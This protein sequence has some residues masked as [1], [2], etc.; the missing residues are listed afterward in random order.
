M[1]AERE[2]ARQGLTWPFETSKPTSSVISFPR[3]HLLSLPKQSPTW[4]PNIEIYEPI[5]ATLAQ[6]ATLTKL[7][8]IVRCTES[9]QNP[10]IRW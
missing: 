1:E 7:K 10:S 5:G 8:F 3:P 6:T 4:E 9:H 2:R